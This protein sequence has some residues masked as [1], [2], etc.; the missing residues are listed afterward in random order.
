[1]L[2]GF[3]TLI[4]QQPNLIIDIICLL[5]AKS[6]STLKKALNML[7][8]TVESNTNQREMAVG[9]RRRKKIVNIDK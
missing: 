1:M 7:K 8:K 2:F 6:Q 4:V 3:N 9:F 5:I